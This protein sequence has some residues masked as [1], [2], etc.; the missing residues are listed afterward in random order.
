MTEAIDLTAFA[1]AVQGCFVGQQIHYFDTVDS[2]MSVARS[3]I[4][5][6]N[7]PV[8]D[9]S[10]TI[11]VADEQTVGRGRRGR[12]WETPH[13]V[14]LLTSTIVASPHLPASPALLPMIASL[15][16]ARAIERSIIVERGEVLVKWPNDLLLLSKDDNRVE[17]VAG[18]L[19]ESIVENNALKYAIIGIGI[20]ANQTKNQLPSPLFGAPNPTS[21]RLYLNKA[22]NRTELLA[23]LCEELSA[24]LIEPNATAQIFSAWRNRIYTL[25]HYVSVFDQL[26]VANTSLSSHSSVV[27]PQLRGKAIDVTVNGDLIVEDD[28]GINHQVSAG[29]VSIRHV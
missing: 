8:A 28:D 19:I 14:A 22:V 24:L 9:L 20:N 21:I 18:I 12:S 26:P 13:G 16:A 3:L 1:S 17:K 23:Q 2:T 29:D 11:I 5:A 4:D 10:G 6:N 25:N 7:S 15:A 27:Q